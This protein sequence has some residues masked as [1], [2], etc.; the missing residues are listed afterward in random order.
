MEMEKEKENVEIV[1]NLATCNLVPRYIA[2]KGKII[3]V[4]NE[5]PLL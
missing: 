4:K 2:Q 5:F 1:I 3:F